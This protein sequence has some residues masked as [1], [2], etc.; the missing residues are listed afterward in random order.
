[1][2]LIIADSIVINRG[3]SVREVELI[4]EEKNLTPHAKRIGYQ[5]K[6]LATGG[7]SAPFGRPLGMR[8]GQAFY[9]FKLSTH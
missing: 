5:L 6:N 9:I 3:E 4:E 7:Q 1:M 8:D 2:R